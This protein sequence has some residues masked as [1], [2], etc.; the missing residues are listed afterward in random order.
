MNAFDWVYNQLNKSLLLALHAKPDGILTLTSMNIFLLA[1]VDFE[2]NL[3]CI[4]WFKTGKCL[5]IEL[6]ARVKM[7]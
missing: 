7:T 6:S 2:L 4:D 3:S 1:T 5:K